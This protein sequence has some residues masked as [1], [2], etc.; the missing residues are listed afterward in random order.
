MEIKK[1][2]R[3]EGCIGC[4]SYALGFPAR[5]HSEACRARI[6]KLMEDDFEMKKRVRIAEERLSAKRPA[7]SQS[8]EPEAPAAQPAASSSAP[9]SSSA[10]ASGS[11]GP[12]GGLPPRA[13]DTSDAAGPAVAEAVPEAPMDESASL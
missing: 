12:S 6:T 2:G 4:E 5:S 13:M 9:A 11:R 7:E 3:T 10:A 1:F 8:V